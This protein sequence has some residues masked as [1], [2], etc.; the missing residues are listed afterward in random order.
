[1]LGFR[2][3]RGHGDHGWVI[4]GRVLRE[5]FGFANNAKAGVTPEMALDEP[6][7]VYPVIQR[8]PY[9]SGSGRLPIL[10]QCSTDGQRNATEDGD[11]LCFV[12]VWHGRAFVNLWVVEEFGAGG[13]THSDAGKGGER[14]RWEELDCSS[15]MERWEVVLPRLAWHFVT[16]FCSPVSIWWPSLFYT[17]IYIIQPVST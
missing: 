10:L 14:M 11:G 13:G 2:V 6:D 12:L 16:F 9:G 3:G 5:M 1:M 17:L 8:Q 7:I 4:A 15:K